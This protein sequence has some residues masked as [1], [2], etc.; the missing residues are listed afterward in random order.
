MIS[1]GGVDALRCVVRVALGGGCD[2]GALMRCVCV[3]DT[4][5]ARWTAMQN[6]QSCS[7]ALQVMVEIL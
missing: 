7:I 5:T 6:K 3:M 2:R 1:L 4:R